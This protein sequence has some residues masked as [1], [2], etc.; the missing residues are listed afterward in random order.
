M[1]SLPSSEKSIH[2]LRQH[3]VHI[4]VI[5]ESYSS[6]TKSALIKEVDCKLIRGCT[7]HV[8]EPLSAIGS[9][10]RI[11]HAVMKEYHFT[12]SSIDQQIL[13]ELAD[14]TLGSPV[15]IDIVSQ[16]LLAQFKNCDNFHLALQSVAS[17]LSLKS[18]DSDTAEP[19]ER[20]Q[21]DFGTVAVSDLYATYSRYDSWESLHKLLDLCDFIPEERLLLHCLSIFGC[22][23]VPFSLINEISST[24][25]KSVQKQHLAS[26]LHTKLVT[27]KFIQVYPLSV[28][29]HHSVPMVMD[30]LQGELEFVCVPQH[31]SD[32]LARDMEE[33][34]LIVAISVAIHS[35]NSLNAVQP[36]HGLMSLLIETLDCNFRLVGKDCFKTAFGL[37]LHNQLSF[38]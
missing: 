9:T 22:L 10:Q 4:V 32:C 12:P 2:I 24:I 31:L 11:V 6:N 1:A 29:F 33:I 3:N 28:I 27:F 15:I 38:S 13:E 35:I 26:T 8:I 37:Y 17:L 16:V 25:T 34:D 20:V 5:Y 21:S 14:F 19:P 36:V 23:P 30:S 7:F 18:Y